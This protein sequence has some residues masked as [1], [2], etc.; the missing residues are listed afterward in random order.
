M[1]QTVLLRTSRALFIFSLAKAKV[2]QR[3]NVT[4]AGCDS[5][6]SSKFPNV[7]VSAKCICTNSQIY[8]SKLSNIFVANVKCDQQLVVV[9][10]RAA[11]LPGSLHC[12]LTP[13]CCSSP[14]TAQPYL[15][16]TAAAAQTTPVSCSVTS[17][18]LSL[19]LDS[20]EW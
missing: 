14:P 6:Y 19:H 13:D 17:T 10:L 2:Q 11:L 8:L 1:Q 15:P 20:R 16:Q 18:N 9:M 4:A 7:F 12:L 3:S 5:L